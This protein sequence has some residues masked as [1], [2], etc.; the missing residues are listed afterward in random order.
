MLKYV[1]KIKQ[2]AALALVIEIIAYI[3]LTAIYMNDAAG[4]TLILIVITFIALVFGYLAPLFKETGEPPDT[5][6]ENNEEESEDPEHM[7]D[8]TEATPVDMDSGLTAISEF[9]QDGIQHGTLAEA[10][11]VSIES[12]LHGEASSV[13]EALRIGASE[14]YK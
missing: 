11:Q 5:Y 7:T 4:L 3:I 1:E 9:I 6:E 12:A 2:F 14:W 13:E 10:M 8:W